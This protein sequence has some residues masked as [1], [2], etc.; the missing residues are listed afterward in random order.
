MPQMTQYKWEQFVSVEKIMSMSSGKMPCE[1]VFPMEFL[2]LFQD[3]I[4][5]FASQPV[6]YVQSMK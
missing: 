2:S 4:A 3:N 5:P 1:F 6:P